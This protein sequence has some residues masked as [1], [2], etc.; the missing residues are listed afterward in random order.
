MTIEFLAQMAWKSAAIAAG[1]LALA[2]LLRGRP[3]DERAAV[4]RAA[5]VLIL[6]L[7][8]LALLL[9]ALPVVAFAAPDAA[10][11]PASSPTA[12]L[13]AA[14][15]AASTEAAMAKPEQA[16]VLDDPTPL[17]LLA[18]F[19][20]FAMVMVRLLA[21][22]WTLRRWTRS[23]EEVECPRWRAA[24][25]ASATSP[26]LAATRLLA[27]D[28]PSPLGWGWLRPVILID[29]DTIRSPEEAE[30]VLAHELAH[31]ERRDWLVLVLAR[32]AVA[33]FWFNPLL[34]LLERR[35]VNEAEE[36]ADAR[37]LA[38][39]EPV[40]YAQTLLSCAQQLPGMPATAIADTG[41]ARRV[42]RILEGSMPAGA[43]NRRL[44]RVAALL[45]V[46]VA[47]PIAALK[48]VAA[49]LEEP[50]V[51]PTP[52]AAPGAPV[53]PAPHSAPAT[54]NAAPAPMAALAPAAPLAPLAGDP[55]FAP[56]PPVPAAPF[57][58][59]AIPAPPAPLAVP[60]LPALAMAPAAP[61]TPPAR[62]R[63]H[64]EPWSEEDQ[65]ELERDLAE[66]GREAREAAEQIRRDMPRI[67]AEARAAARAG[68]A[69]G[70]EGMA[71]GAA[72][73][74]GG[75]RGM[76]AEAD[77]LRSPEYRATQ[78]AKAARRGEHVTDRELQDLIPK[79]REGAEKLRRSAVEMRRNA[80]KM[81]RGES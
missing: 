79:L 2:S 23:G 6:A 72:G 66:A 77:R 15:P 20:G 25:D 21:G 13:A 7:P 33:L 10:A 50:P 12:D 35:M 43:P 64:R 14:L 57:A 16:S 3:A 9:P 60:G 70:A 73:M 22:L 78:I 40:R 4:L 19:G 8:V 46:L 1:A 48:P 26:R 65:R 36:A 67:A 34:W 51:P 5:F 18:W 55:D 42:R 24:F 69:A 68:I 28:A 44:L 52:A 56:L 41:L 11:L 74:E 17:V 81:R 39:V 45:C 29:R 31:V 38:R 76:E 32:V 59:P 30:A 49:S 54:P 27:S 71:A 53:A 63:S 58:R 80:E 47:A 75:A 62:R 61:P 37:A